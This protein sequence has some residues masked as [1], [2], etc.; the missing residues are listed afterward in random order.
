MIIPCC[1]SCCPFLPSTSTD[2]TASRVP[3]PDPAQ[4][5]RLRVPASTAPPNLPAVPRTPPLHSTDSRNTRGSPGYPHGLRR[6]LVPEDPSVTPPPRLTHQ[7]PSPERSIKSPS[8]CSCYSSS[9]PG[10]LGRSCG[11]LPAPG[12]LGIFRGV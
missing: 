2:A 12:F 11:A 6:L 1:A 4:L 3:S 8:G 5:P 7:H 9:L 10:C